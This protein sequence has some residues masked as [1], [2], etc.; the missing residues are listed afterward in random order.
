MASSKALV[1]AW[2][3]F[4]LAASP[5][6]ARSLGEP[7]GGRKHP[8]DPGHGEQRVQTSRFLNLCSV[9]MTTRVRDDVEHICDV[10]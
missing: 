9:A 7:F 8:A 5:A 2:C 10:F 3:C 4:L 6:A 1:F